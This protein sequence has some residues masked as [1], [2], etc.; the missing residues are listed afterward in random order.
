MSFNLIDA[1]P[2]FIDL[3]NS[4]FKDFLDTF[5]IVS[6][7]DIFVYSKIKVEH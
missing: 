6:F 2:A 7:D 1:P 5:V 3:M 4:V